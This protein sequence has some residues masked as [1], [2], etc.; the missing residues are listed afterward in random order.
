MHADRTNGSVED[1]ILFG[2]LRAQRL[3]LQGDK[4]VDLGSR[5]FDSQV[6]PV[7]RPGEWSGKRNLWRGFGRRYSSVRQILRFILRDCA[8]HS[9]KR[10]LINIPGRGY[11]LV[12]PGHL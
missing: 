11:G 2:P 12:C 1:A 6:A 3:L 8:A 5:T 4:A 10:Y 7:E 9:G